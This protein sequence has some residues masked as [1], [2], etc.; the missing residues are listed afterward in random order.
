MFKQTTKMTVFA[1]H[2]QNRLAAREKLKSMRMMAERA[3]HERQKK[4][5][6]QPPAEAA[7]VNQPVQ[8][9]R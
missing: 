6:S 2:E 3:Q 1:A 7:T 5:A 8:A 9:A 4:A